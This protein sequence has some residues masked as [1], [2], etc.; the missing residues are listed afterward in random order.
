M[1]SEWNYGNLQGP[2]KDGDTWARRGTQVLISS[3]LII[4]PTITVLCYDPIWSIFLQAFPQ[5]RQSTKAQLLDERD[6]AFSYCQPDSCL[7]GHMQVGVGFRISKTSTF[8][9][10]ENLGGS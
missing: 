8:P 3:L 6:M 1:E 4:Y 7:R 5:H 2:E 9:V 10:G